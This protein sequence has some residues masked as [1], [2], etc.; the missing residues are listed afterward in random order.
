M[1][2]FYGMTS[3]NKY[4]KSKIYLIFFLKVQAFAQVLFNECDKETWN[5]K[6]EQILDYSVIIPKMNLRCET[7]QWNK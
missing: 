2:K 7:T 6:H 5:M 4:W 3:N 1:R